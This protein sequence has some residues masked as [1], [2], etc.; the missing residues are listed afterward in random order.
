M[1]T[2]NET[3]IRATAD[4]VIEL[5]REVEASGHAAIDE[6]SLVQARAVLHQ[7]VDAMQGVVVNPALGRVTVIHADGSASSIACADLAF[8]MSAV[9]I[10]QTR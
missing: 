6:P 5:G 7:W 4:R 10:T 1:S 8:K 3:K 2:E 9:S